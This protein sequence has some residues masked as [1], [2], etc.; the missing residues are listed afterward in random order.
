MRTKCIEH[1]LQ[2]TNH[3]QAVNLT[4]IKKPTNLSAF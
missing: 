1:N 2:D 3:T 4:Q